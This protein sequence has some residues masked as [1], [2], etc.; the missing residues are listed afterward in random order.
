ML[1]IAI[2]NAPIN[3]RGELC[4]WL[5]EAKP[6]VFIGKVSAAVREEL[7]NSIQNDDHISGALMA[8]SAPTEL[9]FIM[10]IAGEPSRSIVEIDGL[11][12]IK[13]A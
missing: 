13:Q 8:Y 7:W 2:E 5:F 10:E 1:M 9:G 11:Q 3:L 6:G 4:K 12:L